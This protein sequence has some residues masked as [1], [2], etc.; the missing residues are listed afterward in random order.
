M[1]RIIRTTVQIAS[2]TIAVLGISVV[3]HISPA[4]AATIN[5]D[6]SGHFTQI[7]RDDF[8]GPLN[9]SHWAKESYSSGVTKYE[10]YDPSRAFSKG[11]VLHVF[12]KS[13]ASR[14][15]AETGNA[16]YTSTLPRYYSVRY[17]MRVQFPKAASNPSAFYS[18]DLLFPGAGH[19]TPEYDLPETGNAQ[20][21]RLDINLHSGAVATSQ[22]KNLAIDPRLFHIYD[23]TVIPHTVT[24]SIDGKVVLTSSVV[25]T[26]PEYLHFQ[27]DLHYSATS[28]PPTS[29]QIDQQIDWVTISKYN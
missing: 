25:P 24:F 11:G 17:R 7:F 6:S 9:S 10:K 22:H 21:G 28:V 26:T 1:H 14:S 4:Q 3:S 20:K 27:D 16:L 8:S 23:V 19:S 13:T 5:P 18:A 29:D 2:T 12:G 15:I